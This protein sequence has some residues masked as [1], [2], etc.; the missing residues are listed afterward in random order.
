MMKKIL[1]LVFGWIG[2]VVGTIGAI[3]PVLPTVPFLMLATFCFARSSTKLHRWF[4]RTKLYQE[5]LAD[6]VAGKGMTKKTKV[7]IMLTVT[8][9]M[10][11]GFLMMG[12]QGI[13]TGC[14]VLGGIWV[15]H[16]LYF[17]FGIKT[18]PAKEATTL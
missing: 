13:G 2:L 5:N 1:Y 8:L 7:R 3:L 4:V 16:L 11:V 15:F 6:F 14:A 12:L 17:I 10:S 9:L 18:I